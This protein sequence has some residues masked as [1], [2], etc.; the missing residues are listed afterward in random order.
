MASF[1]CGNQEK[2]N[3][4]WKP[5]GERERRTKKNGQGRDC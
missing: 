1:G 2:K 3:Q 4:F 5:E